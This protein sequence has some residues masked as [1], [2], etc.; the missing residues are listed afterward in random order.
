[1]YGK[2][3]IADHRAWIEKIP[4]KVK[5]F[6]SEKHCRN[7]LVQAS[8]KEPLQ[9]IQDYGRIPAKC[10]EL[11]VAIFDLDSDLV[12]ARQ[13]GTK[14]NIEKAKEEFEKLSNNILEILGQY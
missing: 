9:T 6:L 14:E 7:G 8:W 3:P 1:V 5:T 4:E 10:Q 12:D 2:Q 11:G 13:V